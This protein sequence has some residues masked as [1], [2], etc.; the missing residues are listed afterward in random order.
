L[1]ITPNTY[2]IIDFSVSSPEHSLHFI[3]DSSNSRQGLLHFTKLHQVF[4]F[5][6]GGILNLE[7][8]AEREKAL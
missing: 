1:S 7:T 8:A 5:I 3:P 4:A 6:I 2:R